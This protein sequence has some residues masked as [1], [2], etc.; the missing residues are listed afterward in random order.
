MDK[1]RELLPLVHNASIAIANMTKEAAN[2]EYHNND[3]A[4]RT[5]K[6][7]IV[8]FENTELKALKSAV[9]DIRTEINSTPRKKMENRKI[10]MENLKQFKTNNINP[11][12]TEQ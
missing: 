11:K 6:K 12:N 3:K 4:S 2:L 7:A 8:D 5:L 9:N 1:K 10:N